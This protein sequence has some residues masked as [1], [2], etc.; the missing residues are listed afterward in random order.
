MN[1]NLK[2]G[3]MAVGHDPSCTCSTYTTPADGC[4]SSYSRLLVRVGVPWL[5]DD[6]IFDDGW[7]V[8]VGTK[9]MPG[10]VDT[11]NQL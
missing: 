8:P 5:G 6:D 1:L 11:G 2:D 7:Q 3:V 10:K 9:D 4:S